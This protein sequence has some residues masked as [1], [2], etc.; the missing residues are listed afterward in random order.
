MER[1]MGRKTILIL[2]VI[3]LALISLSVRGQSVVEFYG[4]QIPADKRIEATSFHFWMA[5]FDGTNWNDEQ[6]AFLERGARD[7]MS[8]K[9]EQGTAMSLFT[10]DQVRDVFYKIGGYDTS[11][12]KRMW[13]TDV[14]SSKAALLKS[15][16]M[17]EKGRMWR[18]QI[19]WQ[20]M[21]HPRLTP[22]Q[23][24]HLY[25]FVHVFDHPSVEAA[26]ALEIEAV[27]VLGVDLTKE[28]YGPIGPYSSLGDVCRAGGPSIASRASTRASG[29]CSC[30]VGS[31]FNWSCSGTCADG[32]GTCTRTDDGCGFA[33]L[34]NCDGGCKNGDMEI[35]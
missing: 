10:P 9:F 29:N 24:E 11:L 30:S 25:R 31:Y 4:P 32:T 3:G 34:F 20:V 16:T 19:A 18:P 28:I 21:T 1:K 5:Y 14:L 13:R 23:I 17:D 15:L 6:K 8:I 33:G 2:T 22:V 12:V 27:A 35:Q 26:R 7:P